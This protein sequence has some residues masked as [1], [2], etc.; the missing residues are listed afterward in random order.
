MPDSQ[1]H[2]ELHGHTGPHVLLIHGFCETSAVW[3]PWAELL[4]NCRIITIDLPGFGRSPLP[5]AQVSME[6]VAEQVLD[7]VHKNQ[8]KPVVVGHSLGGY[9]ALAMAERAPD[10]LN[11]L[12]LFHS[13]PFPDSDERKVN[14]DKAMAF[15]SEHGVEAFTRGLIPNLF[16]KKALPAVEQAKEMAAAT[17]PATVLAYLAGMR[18][19]ADRSPIFTGFPQKKAILAGKND[20]VVP[21]ESLRP[22]AGVHPKAEL[23]ELENV[24]HMG[25]F[26][27]P[28]ITARIVE[29]FA[30]NSPASVF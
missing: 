21:M 24:G 1:L 15:V 13:T 7:V 28:E 30:H 17:A 29:A 25:M 12:M 16:F 20:S 23:F 6:W 3:H 4:T 8:W 26:E 2:F 14:R 19:R 11:G 5:V 10:S 22:L 9:V 18:N 27:A